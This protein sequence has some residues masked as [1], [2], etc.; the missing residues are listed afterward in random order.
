MELDFKLFEVIIDQ[1]RNVG[2][3]ICMLV[4]KFC[5]VFDFNELDSIIVKCKYWIEV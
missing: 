5:S 3:Y 4:V 1:V 2:N